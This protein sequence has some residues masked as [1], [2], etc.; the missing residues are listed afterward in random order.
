[1][2][3]DKLDQDFRPTN[4][5]LKPRITAKNALGRSHNS[6]LKLPELIQVQEA[7]VEGD[8]GPFSNTFSP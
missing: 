7:N 5:A 8:N 4:V 1:M 6:P 3:F 2:N